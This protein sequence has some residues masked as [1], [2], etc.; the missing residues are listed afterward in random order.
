MHLPV[1]VVELL[2][3]VE[4]ASWDC[5]EANLVWEF[6]GIVKTGIR[7]LQVRLTPT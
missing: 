3:L 1:V 6:V 5:T 2:L 7:M 4:F